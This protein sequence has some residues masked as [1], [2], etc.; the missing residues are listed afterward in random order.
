MAP[1]FKNWVGGTS[2]A[3]TPHDYQSERPSTFGK[4]RN[5]PKLR[6]DDESIL[7][8]T[9]ITAIDAKDRDGAGENYEMETQTG[10]YTGDSGSERRII[11]PPSDLESQKVPEKPT[12]YDKKNGVMVNV[13]YQVSRSD[14]RS[15]G[16]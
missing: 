5:K 12:R 6:P 9:R 4:L 7:C 16:K 2:S 8:T 14:R 11:T 1:L 15:T 3:R 10:N 13:E